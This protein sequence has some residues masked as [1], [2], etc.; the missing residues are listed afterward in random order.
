MN[1][2]ITSGHMGQALPRTNQAGGIAVTDVQYGFRIVLHFPENQRALAR[3]VAKAH[4]DVVISKVKS[5]NCSAEQKKS[6]L[7]S[8][9]T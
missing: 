2:D 7:D 1:R 6:L 5:L 3:R 9:I 4:A 8:I